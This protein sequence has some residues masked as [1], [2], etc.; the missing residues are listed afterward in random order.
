[1]KNKLPLCLLISS[2]VLFTPASAHADEPGV[3]R[4]DT[5]A[6]IGMMADHYH[7]AGEFMFAYRFMH[8]KMEGSRIGRQRVSPE[9]IATTVRNRFFGQPMQPPTLRVV[10][11]RMTMD[12][13]MFGAMY[14]PTDWLTLMAMSSYVEK[15]MDHITFQGGM[16]T[17]ILGGFTTR[18]SGIGDTKFAGLFRLLEREHFRLH[19]TFGISAPT[20]SIKKR[21]QILTPMGGTPSPRLPYPMQLGSGTP[22][23]LMNLT[24]AGWRGAFGWGAQYSATVRLGDNSS[25]YQLGNKRA[26][27]TWASYSFVPEVS[28]AVRFTG[29]TMGRIDGQDPLIVAPVQ[30]ADPNNQGGDQIRMGLSLNVA[31]PKTLIPGAR[32]AFEYE[33]PLYRDLNGP[34]LETDSQFTIGVQYSF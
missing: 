34:Q 22:D 29:E 7:K 8:M 23:L 28:A 19:G 6:P 21:D 13:H 15:E 30:T 9:Q 16:G 14:A 5:H 24:A 1:M 26:L 20:G 27:T 32:L 12:M 11:T 25:D 10:P 4:A 3:Y 17:S 33:L 31:L 18:S 2:L